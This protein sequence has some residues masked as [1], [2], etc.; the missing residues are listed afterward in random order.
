MK[1]YGSIFT[2]LLQVRRAKHLV[3]RLSLVRLADTALPGS[4]REVKLY[5]SLRRKL[6]WVVS[7]LFDF[8][9]CVVVQKEVDA[10]VLERSTSVQE[11][12]DAHQVHVARL[13]D[14]LLLSETVRLI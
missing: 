13:R 8:F 2:F 7:T 1:V 5:Y 4:P 12:V 6:S 14:R 11:V 3:D 9:M 10:A